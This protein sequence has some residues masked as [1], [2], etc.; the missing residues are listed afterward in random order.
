V[1]RD[2]YCHHCG[3]GL[4]AWT[5]QDCIAA[6]LE[7]NAKHGDQ[8]SANEWRK[9]TY[10]HPANATCIRI[11]GSWNA[12]IAAC[13]F[14]P[15]TNSPRTWT[16]KLVTDVMLDFLFTHNRWPTSAEWWK[17]APG[18]PCTA[19]VTT[20]F[21]S[22]NEAKRAA[23]YLG[24]SVSE[25]AEILSLS[26]DTIRRLCNQGKLSCRRTPGGHREI[27]HKDVE[28]LREAA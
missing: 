27:S 1:N 7:W 22:W 11:F 15:R 18:R 8:P 10:R 16:K 17:A 21:G 24:L 19:T 4:P 25:A 26:N 6:A 13:G 3:Q 20:L 12:F 23:G 14:T 2:G 9:A 5:P 28:A